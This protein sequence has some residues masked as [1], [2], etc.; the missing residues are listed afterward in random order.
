MKCKRGFLALKQY[1]CPRSR[2]RLRRRV[3]VSSPDH[4]LVLLA[5]ADPDSEHERNHDSRPDM[6]ARNSS[7]LSCH[8]CIRRARLG[9]RILHARAHCPALAA[10]RFPGCEYRLAPNRLYEDQLLGPDI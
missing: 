9:T 5:Q 8:A 7:S 1:G 6:A 10:D 3:P 2:E 4:V